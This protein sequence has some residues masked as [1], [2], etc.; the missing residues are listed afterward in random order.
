MYF[1]SGRSKA[2]RDPVRISDENLTGFTPESQL[3]RRILLAT[4]I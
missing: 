2:R 4:G 3:V 1:N